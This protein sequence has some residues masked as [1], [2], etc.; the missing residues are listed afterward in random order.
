MPWYDYV[1]CFFGGSFIAN[2]V[3]HFIRGITG[4]KFP[5]P[6]ANPPGRGLS[7]PALN[8]LWA[9][10]N[11]VAGFLLLQTGGFSLDIW[12]LLVTSFAGFAL[13]ALL[14]SRVFDARP[15]NEQPPAMASQRTGAPP[16]DK[17][18]PKDLRKGM[19]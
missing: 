13:M 8:V 10:V 3:P 11:L 4:T 12:Q 14:L 1:F 16:A 2:F 5:T 17:P 9:L 7:P 15:E 18:I 19:N 6:F